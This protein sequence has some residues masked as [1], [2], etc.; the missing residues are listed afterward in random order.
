MPSITQA[1][2][3]TGWAPLRRPLFRDRWLASLVSNVGTW[4]QDTAG[5][6]LMAVLTSSPLLIAL[7]QTA[8]S[9]PILLLGFLAG[10]TADILDRRRLL[11]LWQAWMLGSVALLSVLTLAGHLSPFMLLALTFLLNVGSAMNNPAWQAIIPELVPHSELPDAI[12]FNSAAFNLARA[13]GPAA[14]GLVVAAFVSANRG[15]GVVFVINAVSFVAVILVLYRWKRTPLYKSALPAER[16]FGA[17]RAGLRYIRHSPTLRA[18]LARTFAFT[19]CASAA[20]ALLA[21]VAQQHL[22]QGALGYGLLNGCL[23]LGAVIGAV[24]LPRLRQSY[25]PDHLLMSASAVFSCSLLVLALGTGTAWIVFWLIAAGFAWT[26]TTS[27]FNVA[28]QL[29]VPG[30][31]QARALGAYQTIFWGGVAVGSSLWGFVAE[32]SATWKALLAAAIGL[33]ASIALALRFPVMRGAL[34]NVTPFQ[35][36]RPVPDVAI[37]PRP[38]DGPVLITIEYR[39]LEADYAAFTRAIHLLRGVRLRDGA[40]RWGVYQDATAPERFLETFVVES[41]IEFLRERE[42]MT[43]SDR[44][45]RDHVRSFHR[46]P[47]APSVTY[48]IYAREI[49]SGS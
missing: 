18:V 1:K 5:T 45:I 28:V 48:M 23:G 40:M 49:G 27:T 10:A 43:T 8:A 33:A 17:M 38:D 20:W 30:W 16:L 34:P 41:W 46:G 11:I 24:C 37:H 21:V 15:A 22:H 36:D 6:W 19:T 2:P 42:R 26:S 14:G 47:S 4:M 7:M 32:H 35:R 3:T 29:S 44:E 13:V 31:V 9:L 39:V 12:T 25:Q